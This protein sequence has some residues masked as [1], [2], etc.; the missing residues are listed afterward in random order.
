MTD[1]QQHD[2]STHACWNSNT[3][4]QRS[5]PTNRE[6]RRKLRQERVHKVLERKLQNVSSRSAICKRKEGDG[7]GKAERPL[8]KGGDGFRN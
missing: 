7:K 5:S 2:Q 1:K 3:K 6:L 4:H 8:G